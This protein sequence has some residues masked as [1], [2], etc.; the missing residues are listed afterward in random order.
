MGYKKP[1]EVMELLSDELDG[2]DQAVDRLER[3][4]K[5]VDN[6]NIRPDTTEMESMLREHLEL[7]KAK[8]AQLEGSFQNIGERVSKASLVRKAQLRLHYVIWITSLIIIGYLSF[9]VSGIND[10]R[11]KAYAEGQ[12][13]V[14]SSLR[15]YFDRNPGHY[16]SYRKWTEEKDSVPNQK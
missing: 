10:I 8:I 14:I 9:R 3:L 11:K 2:F 6:I 13:Q 12:E 4:T 1:E 16:K 15:D 5:N 7:E